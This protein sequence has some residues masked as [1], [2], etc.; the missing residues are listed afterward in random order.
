MDIVIV[1]KAEWVISFYSFY[2]LKVYLGLSDKEEEIEDGFVQYANSKSLRASWVGEDPQSH[3]KKFFVA[4]G[5]RQGDTSVTNGYIDMGIETSA[6]INLQLLS[7]DESGII[8][9]VA[10]KA[11]NGAGIL[12]NPIFSKPIKILEE[13][14]PGVIYDG[15]EQNVDKDS[16]NDKFS[17]GMHFQG[18]ESEACN[19]T[20]Y[21][22]AIG[23]QPYLTDVYEFT[24]YGLIYN[25]T[26]G[27]AQ[28]HVQL[29]ENKTYYVTV[30]AKTGHN[31]HEEYI[32]S[33]SDG[34]TTDFSPPKISNISPLHDEGNFFDSNY[35]NMYQAYL[36]SFEYRWNVSDLSSFRY[37]N[38]S[39]GTLPLTHD[40]LSLRP[41]LKSK[42]EPG[43]FSPRA[44][45]SLF[46]TVYAMDVVEFSAT[47]VSVPIVADISP[48]FI[49]MFSCT[50]VISTKLSLVKC[51]WISKE[52]ESKLKQVIIRIGSRELSDNIIKNTTLPSNINTWTV[53]VKNSFKLEHLSVIYAT[54][55]VENVLNQSLTE[56]FQIDIDSSAPIIENVT[57]VTWINPDKQ[58]VKQICQ[59]PQS[60]VD[61]S[62]LVLEDKES[63]LDRYV[64]CK[65]E[66][67]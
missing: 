6:D 34:I 18:F 37:I 40:V 2:S 67:F 5:T 26:H 4:I 19:I 65:I 50:Q 28:A 15:C 54:L 63:G 20:G 30:K 1:K 41:S 14:V 29:D 31:C 62:I 57:F 12:S 8:Y 46:V 49:Q 38:F 3:I 33:T 10:V 47:G 55:T 24:K 58:R 7:F 16:T 64:F 9:Y 43:L 48:P 25:E 60:Y 51:S 45:E 36:D 23:S 21:E 39:V 53:D 32:V 52:E 59:Q 17:I 56:T 61:V 44:G 66:V 22:W 42:I 27:K 11:E 13:N 35:Q